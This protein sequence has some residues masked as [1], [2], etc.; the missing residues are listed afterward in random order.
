MAL[1]GAQDNVKLGNKSFDLKKEVISKTQLREAVER[2]HNCKALWAESLPV[3]EVFQGRT[4]WQGEVQV[5]QLPGH[6][7]TTRCYAWSY[8]TD[9]KTGKRNFF[10]VPHQGP[11]D[12]PQ[13]AVCAA[14]VAEFRQR[15]D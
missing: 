13:T 5:F 9:E 2:L 14:I 7:T 11:V 8:V 4:V 6:P 12:S 3:E 10:A 1:L 15:A